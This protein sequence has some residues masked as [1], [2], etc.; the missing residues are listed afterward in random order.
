M[1]QLPKIITNQPSKPIKFRGNEQINIDLGKTLI[2]QGQSI[3]YF[4]DFHSNVSNFPKMVGL[5]NHIKSKLNGE[6]VIKVCSGDFLFGNEPRNEGLITKILNK[7]KLDFITLGNH[8]FDSTPQRLKETL[9]KLSFPV[10]V[11]N[12]TEGYNDLPVKSTASIK[13]HQ[14]EFGA[15]GVTI[16]PKFDSKSAYQINMEETIK[17]IQKNVDQLAK[18]GINK[19]ILTSHLGL[20]N[21]KYIAKETSGVDIIISSHNHLAINGVK[22]GENV[23]LSKSNEP[24]AILQAAK[25]ND[26]LGYARVAFDNEG[27]LTKIFNRTV[28]TSLKGIKEDNGAIEMLSKSCPVDIIGYL[29]NEGTIDNINYGENALAN[30]LSDCIKTELKDPQVVLLPS[31]MIRAGLSS[32]KIRGINIEEMLPLKKS[33]EEEVFTTMEVSGSK[34]IELIEQ[35]NNL[36]GPKFGRLITHV[37]GLKY[38]INSD[39]RIEDVLIEAQ[40]GLFVPVIGNESYKIALPGFLMTP[41]RLERFALSNAK[42]IR[43]HNKTASELIQDYLKTSQRLITL[44]LD[45]R[46]KVDNLTDD[47]L[48]YI[49]YPSF[50][51][52]VRESQKCEQSMQVRTFTV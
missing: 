50:W 10:L 49:N 16:G 47:Q 32:G 21:D 34:L 6:K 19:V 23:L 26:Y 9:N 7:I 40:K 48:K 39:N 37:S 52:K 36:K 15:I 5:I 1:L 28:P 4:S 29:C 12:S 43:N 30:W 45:G 41:K 11:A 35:I 31:I 25:N 18:N 2:P 3:M 51:E 8:E 22:A 42:I 27:V 44:N 17:T 13:T 24:V 20:D 33:R 46:I 38:R 14:D